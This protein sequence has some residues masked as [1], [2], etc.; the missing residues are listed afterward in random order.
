MN[1]IKPLLKGLVHQ[2]IGISGEIKMTVFHKHACIFYAETKD[3]L[4][5]Y[6][7]SIYIIKLLPI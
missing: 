4:F 2:H 1:M 3:I 6:T 5:I 7:A